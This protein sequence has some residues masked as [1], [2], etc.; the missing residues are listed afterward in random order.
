MTSQ[1]LDRIE[2][3]LNLVLPLAY[4]EFMQSGK[5]G[6]GFAGT[7]DL[8]G[9]A[10]EVI[11]MTKDARAN[12]FFGAKWP[13]NYLVIGD[14]GAGDYYFTDV[15]MET[16]AVQFAEH[17]LTRKDKLVLREDNQYATFS[18]FWEDMER[19]YRETD[20]AIERQQARR[21]SKRWW[22]FWVS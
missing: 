18:E 11:E 4:R 13:Q 22:Q 1:D 5:F 8:N 16:P 7:Q 17:E 3:E 12:G 9:E 19:C 21:K 15:L 2:K 20:L 6:E 14:D 10:D